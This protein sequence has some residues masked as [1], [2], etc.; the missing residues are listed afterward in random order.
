MRALLTS[1]IVAASLALAACATPSAPRPEAPAAL[2]ADSLFGAPAEEVGARD[3][4]ALSEDMRR[5]AQVEMAALIRKHGAQGALIEALYRNGHLKL[6]YESA[7]TRNAAQAF[8]ARAG[9]CLS[10]V[11][12]TAAFARELGLQVRYQSAYL[13]ETWS[14]KGNLLLRSGHVNITLGRRIADHGLNP[15]PQD[16]TIDFLPQEELRNLRTVEIP[17]SLVVAMFMNNRAVE[18]LV[19]ERLDDAYAWARA[20][21]RADASFLAAQNTL[22]VVYLRRGALGQAGVVFSH[23][24]AVEPDHTR[25]LANLAEVA[26]REGRMTDAAE[27]RARLARL[28]PEPPLHFFNLGLAAMQREDFRTAR[29]L[30][31]KEVARGDA[32]AEVHFWLGVAHHR[33]GDAERATKELSLA[34]E[35]SA[36]RSERELYSAKLDWLRTH[37]SR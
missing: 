26:S 30:F 4:F 34:A 1:V 31:A 5:Y 20:A 24:L 35:V 7:V 28:E 36:S 23:V 18:A 27:L 13:E 8:D 29:E 16:M 14:R 21:V 37:R 22:G 10:L 3:I 25:A 9:N 2:F 17:E 32:S 33:L 19:R 15:F 6:E 12:L 11:I